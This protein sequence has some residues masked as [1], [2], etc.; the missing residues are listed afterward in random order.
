[1]EYLYNYGTKKS[2]D[3]VRISCWVYFNRDNLIVFD[4]KMP[5]TT[6]LWFEFSTMNHFYYE[7]LEQTCTKEVKGAFEKMIFY[8][9]VKINEFI[10]RYLLRDWCFDCDLEH[11]LDGSLTPSSFDE[12]MKI[13]AKILHSILSRYEYRISLTDEEEQRIAM[14]AFFLFESGKSV[15]SPHKYISQYCDMVSF[16]SKFGLNYFD[17]QKLPQEV[18]EGIRKIMALDNEHS[19]KRMDKMNKNKGGK[20]VR[21]SGGF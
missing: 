10:V 21:S 12:V 13:N 17:I 20:N 9:D 6:E 11:R 19:R 18:Y 1:M 4:N 7:L 8:D 2:K 14:Q 5:N 15:Q 3:T 16:W